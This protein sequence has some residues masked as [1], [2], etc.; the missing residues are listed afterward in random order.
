M[1]AIPPMTKFLEQVQKSITLT[2][3]WLIFVVVEI[4]QKIKH[5]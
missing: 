4:Y 2:L 5:V 1:V 3:V